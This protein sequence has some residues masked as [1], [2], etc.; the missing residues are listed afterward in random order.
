MI[1]VFIRADASIE[2]SSGH[3]MRCLTL[4][5]ELIKENVS[6]VF[7]SRKHNGN[8]NHLI[9]RKGFEVIELEKPKLKIKSKIKNN[10]N[11][12]D[13]SLWLGVSEM[14]DAQDTINALNNDKPDWMIV[15]HYALGKTW[16]NYLRPYV[17][18]IMVI[19]DLAN[20]QHDCDILLD[21]NWFENLESRYE[22]ILQRSCTKL[23]GPQYAL[24][25][26]EFTIAKK[27]IN[28]RNDKIKR[29]FIFLGV[30][31]AII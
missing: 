19:D 3:I 8:L 1:K 12:D 27:T 4:A 29:I 31:I 15:D 21:H 5:Q 11:I 9:L 17:S 28:I 22:G 24:L 16:E 18:N 30:L 13:Y 6:V 10:H 25:R 20:R 14:R 2:I 26:P 7:I 23:L